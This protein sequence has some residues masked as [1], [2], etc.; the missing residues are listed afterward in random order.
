VTYDSRMADCPT[1]DM[2]GYVFLFSIMIMVPIAALSL[3]VLVF[4]IA[5]RKAGLVIGLPN[6]FL[7]GAFA[8]GLSTGAAT[9]LPAVIGVLALCSLGFCVAGLIWAPRRPDRIAVTAPWPPQ[10]DR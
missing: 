5:R 6:A 10:P 7:V 4:L 2:H 1:C 9:W 8:T 3:I